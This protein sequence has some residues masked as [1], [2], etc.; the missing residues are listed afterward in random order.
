M[1]HLDQ[2]QVEGAI[3]FEAARDVLV[4]LGDFEARVFVAYAGGGARFG[5]DGWLTYCGPANGGMINL[6]S[7][8]IDEAMYP[9]IIE[10][11]GVEPDKA[12]GSSKDH[13]ASLVSSIPSTMR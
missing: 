5:Y 3:V 11:R 4:S 12:S 6:D 8:E 10:S 1:R 9:F 13:P 7:V 2:C